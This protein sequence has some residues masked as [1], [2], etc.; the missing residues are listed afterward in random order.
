MRQAKDAHQ[1]PALSE[2]LVAPQ[3]LELLVQRPLVVAVPVVCRELLKPV[4]AAGIH[5]GIR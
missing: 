1:R 5:G 4:T 3:Q 2:G